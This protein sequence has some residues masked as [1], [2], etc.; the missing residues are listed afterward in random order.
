MNTS[1]DYAQPGPN[2]F[3]HGA[4]SIYSSSS[5]NGVGGEVPITAQ[6][7][8][9]PPPPPPPPPTATATAA[10]AAA[11]T[12]TAAPSAT[13][14]PKQS[15]PTVPAACLACRSKHLKCDGGN[16]CARCQASESICQYVA[17]RRGY[18]G[19]RRNGTQNPNKRH[20]AASDD[21][22]PNSN[23]SN[24][25]CPMLLGAGVATP[26]A[27]SLSAFNPGLGIPET[28]MS[29]IGATPS[30]SGLQIYRQPYLDAN[31][32]LV[33]IN[34]RKAP[35]TIAERC[36]DSFY[37]HFFPGHPSV[38]PK[39]YLLRIAEQR[40]I[41]HLLAAMRWAG[42]L[43]FEVGPTRATFFEEAMRLMYAKDVPKD[44]F[45]VQA[46][47]I[48][49]V[50]LD[51]SCQQERARDILSDAERIAIEIG[52][53]Q[54]SF[55]AIHGQG[56][57][58]I[59]ES[60]RRTWWDLFV[61]DGMVAGVHRQTNF[62]LFDIVADAGLPCEEH[63][64]LAGTIPRPLYLDDFDN[65]IFSGEEYEFS[66]FAY[67]VASIRNLGRMMR[68][69]ESVFPGDNNV[70]RVENFLS[71]WR[72]HLPASKR[73]CLNKD[74]K[75]DEMMFQAWM[76]NHA[77]SI[78]LHQPLSQLDSSPARDVTSCAPYQMVRSGDTFNT[79][80][81]HI[82]TAAAEIS[83]MVTYAVPITCHTHFFTCVLTL[84]SIVHLSKWAL[85]FVQN[86][87]DLRQQIRL[88]IGALNKLST[89]WSAASRASGQV[90]GVAQEIFRS[91]KAAQQNNA[92]FW[93]GFTQE[94]IISSMAADETIMS[95]INTMLEPVTT[96]G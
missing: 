20:A 15:G 32:A 39:D 5:S 10:T 75:L 89:V 76:I 8:R 58:V 13:G 1:P 19:P 53:F 61:V 34:P 95:E 96:S 37:F 33:D 68:L 72:M 70:D 79:H 31:G 12:T 80:T 54:R 18:K 60:W 49:L 35:Q 42:S 74:M 22:S 41:E 94:E 2:Q 83:K 91:K 84:S 17:S 50:G 93:V 56:I 16:P 86:D 78:M 51:G 90:K 36:I 63:Q 30:Y 92:S 4:P 44:G 62:L 65:D 40:N 55:A 85:W 82:V 57:P 43:Y 73:D 87:D 45:L 38:L 29:T 26:A 27:P 52:L 28:P 66:S 24:E 64:Y 88:N 6:L 71:N 25:S 9:G 3:H 7:L 48:V 69:P 77:C 46:M 81:R 21:G 59:E 47:L 14:E 11:T 23:G 67:R